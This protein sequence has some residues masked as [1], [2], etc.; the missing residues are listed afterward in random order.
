MPVLWNTKLESL[1]N[2]QYNTEDVRVSIEM[3]DDI[4]GYEDDMVQVG[5]YLFCAKDIIKLAATV[6]HVTTTY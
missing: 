4:N 5:D 6:T 2:D 3:G 1:H